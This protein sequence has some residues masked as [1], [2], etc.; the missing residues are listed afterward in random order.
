MLF[1]SREGVL[2]GVPVTPIL[3]YDAH[4]KNNLVRSG[5]LE[6]TAFD[7]SSIVNPSIAPPKIEI[8]AKIN[9]QAVVK[10]P[11]HLGNQIQEKVVTSFNRLNGDVKSKKVAVA[12]P[13]I[14][15]KHEVKDVVHDHTSTVDLST[16][17][18]AVSNPDVKCLGK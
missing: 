14:G 8:K 6:N 7:A 1:R 4:I 10:T 11:V 9:Y 5:D 18:L 16:G 12:M 2:P 13:I 17:K 15:I 3:N